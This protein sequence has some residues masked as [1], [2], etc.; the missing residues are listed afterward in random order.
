MVAKLGLQQHVTFTGRV[1]YEQLPEMPTPQRMSL[2]FQRSRII[3]AL[4]PF[5]ALTSGL[6]II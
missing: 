3:R 4:A 6:P 1:P 2:S 5:E